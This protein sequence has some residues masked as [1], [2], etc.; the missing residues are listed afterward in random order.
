MALLASQ[1]NYR[2]YQRNALTLK[3]LLLEEEDRKLRD[4]NKILVAKGRQF[5][6]LKFHWESRVMQSHSNRQETPSQAFQE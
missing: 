3:V 1:S 6:L 4:Q 5:V 2:N